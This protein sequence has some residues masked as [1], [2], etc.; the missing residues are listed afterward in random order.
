MDRLRLLFGFEGRVRRRT[1][2]LVAIG[3]AIVQIGVTWIVSQSMFG[4]RGAEQVFAAGIDAPPQVI[5]VSLLCSAPFIWVQVA[6]A[7]KRFHDRDRRA[8]PV[9][10]LIGVTSIAGYVPSDFFTTAG[11]ALDDGLIA[12]AGGLALGLL[13]IIVNLYLLIVLGFLDGTRG[14]NRFGQSPKSGGIG[15]VRDMVSAFD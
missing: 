11:R 12:G 5:A 3:G 8:L 10:I 6:M 13:V 15:T 7:A 1:W 14:P 9:I 4:P 2:W